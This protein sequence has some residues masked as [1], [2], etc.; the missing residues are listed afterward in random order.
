MA[1]DPKN[2]LKHVKAGL[3]KPT[4]RN[5]IGGRIETIV[6]RDETNQ[7]CCVECNG[8]QIIQLVCDGRRVYL[9]QGQAQRLINTL[10]RWVRTGNF[11]S[12]DGG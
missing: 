11:G 8:G 10:E 5:D 7:P 12:S 3:G 1:E 9:G 2:F 4:Y 6:F